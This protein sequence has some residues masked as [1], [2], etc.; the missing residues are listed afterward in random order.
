MLSMA[1]TNSLT[2]IAPGPI[3]C[4]MNLSNRISLYILLSQSVSVYESNCINWHTHQQGLMEHFLYPA[5]LES[6]PTYFSFFF[7][8]FLPIPSL[9]L[10]L[11][12]LSVYHL[13]IIFHSLFLLSLSSI[14]LPVLVRLLSMWFQLKSSGKRENACIRLA[15]RQAYGD[16]FLIICCGLNEH[17]PRSLYIWIFGPQLVE[18]FR[19][20]L[21]GMAL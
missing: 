5:S 6:L 8:P 16:L 10:S 9:S 15:C 17:G 14:Y 1:A 19:D 2:F 12:L 7:P 21:G 3:V 11:S 18:L 4:S 20:R 13:S